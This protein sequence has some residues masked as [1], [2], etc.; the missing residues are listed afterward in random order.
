MRM[1]HESVPEI[2]SLDSDF[3]AVPQ[4]PGAPGNHLA[5]LEVFITGHRE[6]HDAICGRRRKTLAVAFDQAA[7]P[8]LA[9]FKHHLDRTALDPRGVAPQQGVVLPQSLAALLHADR[10]PQQ[11]LLLH[12]HHRLL[13]LDLDLVL[14]LELLNDQRVTTA[15]TG[16]QPDQYKAKKTVF[17]SSD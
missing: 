4:H 2:R 10:P 1:A 15:G 3:P 16:S 14:Q 9:V 13:T 17:H 7:G 6:A 11:S 12:A 5:I 8:T